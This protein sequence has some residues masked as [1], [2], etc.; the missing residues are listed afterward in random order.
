MPRRIIAVRNGD[1]PAKKEY[2][3]I[4]KR[5]QIVQLKSVKDIP[6]PTYF[7][8]L[9]YEKA[10]GKN[11]HFCKATGIHPSPPTPPY[12]RILKKRVEGEALILYGERAFGLTI[13]LNI[14]YG[15]KAVDPTVHK[16]RMERNP[17][18]MFV[19]LTTFHFNLPKLGQKSK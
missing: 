18:F 17:F 9:Y 7:F 15:R 12:S 16:K 5:G 6:A 11:S 10:G 3:K 13:V 8:F 4:W 2:R 14:L 1:I 19:K